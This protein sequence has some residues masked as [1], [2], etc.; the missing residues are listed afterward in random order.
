MIA[1]AC[2]ANVV[3]VGAVWD[4]A[5]G[6][7]APLGCTDPD[8]QPDLVACFSNSGATTDLVAPGAAITSSK[9]GGGVGTPV[10]GTSYATPVAAGCAAV[11]LGIHWWLTPDQIET[12]LESSSTAVTDAK[13]GLS[14]PRVDCVE[15]LAA[16]AQFVPTLPRSGV[17][18][19]A[20][21]LLGAAWAGRRTVSARGL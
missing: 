17:A 9:L 19:L 14:F 3:S 2:I 6:S 10:H 11:L 15:A 13:N 7:Q 1:P 16:T 4:A 8:T 20:L 5:L 21:L 12:A 18:L